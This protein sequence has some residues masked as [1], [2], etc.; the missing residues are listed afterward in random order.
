MPSTDHVNSGSSFSIA[1]DPLR[2]G[3]GNDLDAELLK[4]ITIVPF[5]IRFSIHKIE[6]RSNVSIPSGPQTPNLESVTVING[7]LHVRRP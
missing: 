4:W 7:V 1:L 2:T 6:A 5:N 3:I